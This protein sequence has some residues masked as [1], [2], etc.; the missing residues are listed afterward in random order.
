MPAGREVGIVR[1][2]H[3]V[4][5]GGLHLGVHSRLNGKA[6]GVQQLLC[7]GFRNV[8]LVHDVLHQLGEQCIGKVRGNGRILLSILFLGQ[9]QRLGRCVAVVLFADHALLPHVVH[10]E[11]TAVDQVFGVGVGVIVGGVFGDGRNGR[12]LPQCQLA[13]ILIKVFVGRSLHALNGAGKADGVQVR[14]QNG[15]LGIAAAQAEGTIDLTQLAQCAIDT[16]GAVVIGQVFDELLFQ[17]GRTLLGAVDG[18][19]ILIDHCADGALEVDA[20]LVVEIL[21]LRADERILQVSRDLFQICPHAVAVGGAQGR[22]LHLCTSVRVGGH[23]HAGLAQFNVI[24]IQQIAVIGRGLH[25]VIDGTHSQQAACHY[26]QTEQGGNGPANEPQERMLFRFT[27]FL[28]LLRFPSGP[29]SMLRFP[30]A[31]ARIH[32]PASGRSRASVV[33]AVDLLH[34]GNRN[35]LLTFQAAFQRRALVSSIHAHTTAHNTIL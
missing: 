13:D 10:E 21:I 20:G 12:T 3:Q 15:L 23:H 5:H 29:G 6:A 28:Q 18:Q 4:F 7:L 31:V 9:Y 16:A 32:P 26:A 2:E 24:Q 11:V 30:A 35:R 19:Q 34:I 17:R 22:V 25:H 27:G 33:G 1:V 14:F 8:F